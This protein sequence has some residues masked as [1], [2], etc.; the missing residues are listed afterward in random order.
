M[1]GGGREGAAGV[2]LVPEAGWAPSVGKNEQTL[3]VAQPHN[4]GGMDKATGTVAHNASPALLRA[5]RGSVL[6]KARGSGTVRVDD[7]I[8]RHLPAPFSS[9]IENGSVGEGL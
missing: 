7:I 9:E 5:Q 3:V 1:P 2:G 8:R 4:G 6:D